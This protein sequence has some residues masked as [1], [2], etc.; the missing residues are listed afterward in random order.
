ML[1]DLHLNPVIDGELLCLSTPVA[2][3]NLSQVRCQYR[4]LQDRVFDPLFDIGSGTLILTWCFSLV[5]HL[6]LFLLGLSLG[7]E[8]FHGFTPDELVSGFLLDQRVNED[9]QSFLELR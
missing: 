3:K 9:L 4:V 8:Y 2:F 1:I 7:A 6:L 5:V